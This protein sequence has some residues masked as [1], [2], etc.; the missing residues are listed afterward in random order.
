MEETFTLAANNY[1]K[2]LIETF[3]ELRFDKEFTDVTLVCDDNQQVKAH[4]IIL[5]SCSALFQNILMNNPHQHP[6]IFF[7]GIPY[8]NLQS[9][10]NFVYL[11]QTEVKQGDLESFLVSAKELQIN[12]L[13][14][15]FQTNFDSTT[16]PSMKAEMKT[17]AEEEQRKL[18]QSKLPNFLDELKT[19]METFDLDQ[20]ESKSVASSRRFTSHRRTPDASKMGQ[21]QYSCDKCEYQATQSIHLKSHKQSKHEGIKYACE[22]CGKSYFDTS[23][24]RRHQKNTHLNN[25]I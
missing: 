17:D 4:K 13:V 12:G 24:L 1:E 3:K 2:N 18:E 5:R 7:K 14:Q 9:V 19:E 6:L 10:L 8:A 25:R 16:E 20:E 21:Y 15:G 11:G 23:T 22:Q